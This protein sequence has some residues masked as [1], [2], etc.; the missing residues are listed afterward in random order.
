MVGL[1]FC[2]SAGSSVLMCSG[3]SLLVRCSAPGIRSAEQR[4]KSC[5][6]W[7]LG[8]RRPW[9]GTL[10]FWKS[11]LVR[12]SAPG[13]RSAP[14]RRKSCHPWR[15]GPRRPWRGTLC[16]ADRIPC[17]LGF[18]SLFKVSVSWCAGVLVCWCA[19]VLVCWCA[20]A[21]LVCP[22][23]EGSLG[24]PCFLTGRLEVIRD[25]RCQCGAFFCFPAQ[26]TGAVSSYKTLRCAGRIRLTPA[27]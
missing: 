26:Q 14:Q 17:A 10:C 24:E 3:E 18:L 12:C 7:Q 9:R 2:G 19:G 16:S 21:F 22:R 25:R 8:P 13:I 23:F 4:R 5:H 11:L 1:C 6:P 27:V 15:L 20:G